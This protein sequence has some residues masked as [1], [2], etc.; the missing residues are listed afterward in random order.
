MSSQERKWNR[1]LCTSDLGELPEL[2]SL[3]PLTPLGEE[4][5]TA[6]E[7]NRLMCTPVETGGQPDLLCTSAGS[8]A[9]SLGESEVNPEEERMRNLLCTSVLSEPDVL[10]TEGVCRS[11]SP[12]TPRIPGTSSVRELSCTAVESARG[13]ESSVLCSTAVAESEIMARIAEDDADDRQWLIDRGVVPVEIDLT[14]PV[15]EFEDVVVPEIT[16][17]S[18]FKATFEVLRLLGA[19]AD[20]RVFEVVEKATGDV[21]AAKFVFINSDLRMYGR[22]LPYEMKIMISLNGVAGVPTLVRQFI[23]N[24][25]TIFS[26]YL[27]PSFVTVMSVP[28]APYATLTEMRHTSD[29]GSAAVRTVFSNLVRILRDLDDRNICHVDLHPGNVMVSTRTKAVTLIDYGRA[30]YKN[31]PYE[32]GH[33]MGYA[34]WVGSP[35]ELRDVY[36]RYKRDMDATH[37]SMY[38]TVERKYIPQFR[39]MFDYDRQ[40]VWRVGFMIY[41]EFHGRRFYQEGIHL[42]PSNIVQYP[43]GMPTIA[44]NLLKNIFVSYDRRISLRELFDHPYFD[45]SVRVRK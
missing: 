23:E 39:Q 18:P 16:T 29:F 9:E 2:T 24:E 44:V 7:W 27:Q 28:E 26:K 38:G 5:A 43:Y 30:E 32:V 10:C 21:F 4:A 11:R 19:G 22:R 13:G 33:I 1:L 42:D 35:P 6:S 34:N 20:G 14:R 45:L 15:V 40:I 25:M 31:I 36:R 17:P 41:D 12:R 8:L 3:S 37:P